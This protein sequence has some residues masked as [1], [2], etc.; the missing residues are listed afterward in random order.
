MAKITTA[1]C[2]GKWFGTPSRAAAHEARCTKSARRNAGRAS[3]IRSFAV[4]QGDYNVS[5]RYASGS[6]YPE[7]GYE[8]FYR[9]NPARSNP[10]VWIKLKQ[11]G[12][13]VVRGDRQ[14][15][16]PGASGVFVGSDRDSED[17]DK[18]MEYIVVDG[19]WHGPFA[20]HHGQD[21]YKIMQKAV[22]MFEERRRGK[23]NP[24]KGRSR[25]DRIL[26]MTQVLREQIG[27]VESDPMARHIASAKLTAI[28]ELAEAGS[29]S[30]IPRLT[31]S[32]RGQF[33]GVRDPMARGFI[34]HALNSIDEFASGKNPAK[35]AR[36]NGAKKPFE[37]TTSRR[38]GGYITTHFPGGFGS[39]G[40]SARFSSFGAAVDSA[41][42]WMKKHG[43]ENTTISGQTTSNDGLRTSVKVLA[44]GREHGEGGSELTAF[45]EW[46]ST[47]NSNEF[48]VF[49]GP[50]GLANPS[51]RGKTRQP[52]LL[53]VPHSVKP[54]K[55]ANAEWVY[56]GKYPIGD[57]YHAKLAVAAV[58]RSRSGVR[59]AVW[60]AVVAQY[61]YYDW[62]MYLDEQKQVTRVRKSR[63]NPKK[64]GLKLGRAYYDELPTHGGPYLPDMYP[65]GQGGRPAVYRRNPRVMS[66]GQWSRVKDPFPLRGLERDEDHDH[67]AMLGRLHELGLVEDKDKRRAKKKKRGA[68]RVFRQSRDNPSHKAE[69]RAWMRK[70]HGND[71][72][73]N[74][75]LKEEYRAMV[76]VHSSRRARKNGLGI[77]GF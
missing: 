12:D 57:L 9:E 13:R 77:Q 8:Q 70:K 66:S 68:V 58:A 27:G 1:C 59:D 7:Y 54:G 2:P 47:A 16:Q 43:A 52:A 39:H 32:L 62:A 19:E 37:V 18:T 31:Q 5:S 60:S 55:K 33:G 34:S 65:Y 11:E 26:G 61:P 51:K 44:V 75:K 40:D 30:R 71:W 76:K 17:R 74:K 50:V 72:S 23:K 4:E 24:S 41:N 35:R 10:S 36:K 45:I 64:T 42:D 46:P 25:K 48:P 53:P 73:K 15:K 67:A 28:D 6:S 14:Y 3:A 29:F 56:A 38:S 49:I 69:I 63:N 20:A 21:R 22:R